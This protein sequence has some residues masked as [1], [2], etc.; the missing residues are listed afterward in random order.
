[1][2]LLD[3]DYHAV[4]VGIRDLERDDLVG[5]QDSTARQAPGWMSGPI[6][7]LN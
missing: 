4:V 6:P 3:A 7:N 2:S 1:M 5:V